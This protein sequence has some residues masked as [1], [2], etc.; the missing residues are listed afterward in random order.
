[1]PKYAFVVTAEEVQI[2]ARDMLGR[3]LTPDET[4]QLGARLR[5]YLLYD[6][7]CG[8]SNTIQERIALDYAE[9]YQR[10]VDLDTDNIRNLIIP[11]AV[12]TKVE[13]VW[14]GDDVFDRKYIGMKG[15][16]VKLK[17][18]GGERGAVGQSPGNPFLI[19][20]FPDGTEDGFWKEELRV[21]DEN[22]THSIF[23]ELRKWFEGTKE[24]VRF[25]GLL[26]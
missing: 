19:V 10:R 22:Y 14:P 23:D 15:V 9:E 7:H 2:E 5:Q 4:T 20:R 1:M 11:P 18:D 12:G 17:E 25:Y 16:V 26:C 21:I 8:F 24:D 13:V 3:D 6:Q